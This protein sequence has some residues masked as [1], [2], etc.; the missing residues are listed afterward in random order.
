[1]SIAF[2]FTPGQTLG[3]GVQSVQACYT[4]WRLVLAKPEAAF[5]RFDP[6]PYAPTRDERIRER[7]VLEIDGQR[8]IC[9]SAQASRVMAQLPAP[10]FASS[11]AVISSSWRRAPF[12]GTPM[13]IRVGKRRS[14]SMIMRRELAAMM[15]AIS[16]E[17]GFPDGH[18]L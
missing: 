9:Q 7:G 13:R 10:Q 14:A 15:F 6:V 4:R 5:E 2:A 12:G 1:M 16:S 3:A 11:H 8:V 17:P 18:L